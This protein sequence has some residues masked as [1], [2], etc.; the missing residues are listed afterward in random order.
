[1]FGFD[2][3]VGCSGLVTSKRAVVVY[4]SAVYGPQYRPGFGTDFQQPFFDEWLDWAGITDHLSITFRPNLVT[5]DA[6]TARRAVHEQA[7]ELGGSI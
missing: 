6:D 1:M 2:P 4:T 7:R 5:G 3:A